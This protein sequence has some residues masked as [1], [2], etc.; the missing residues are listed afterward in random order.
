MKILKLK[1]T[2]QKFNSIVN[3]IIVIMISKDNVQIRS[4]I[5]KLYFDPSPIGRYKNF[6]GASSGIANYI[7]GLDEK[8]RNHFIVDDKY[9]DYLKYIK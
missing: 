2:K 9:I 3:K 7:K 8:I 1:W 6:S 5:E 4:K